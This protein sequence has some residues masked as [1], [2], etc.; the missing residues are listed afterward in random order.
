MRNNRLKRPA[1]RK[2]PQRKRYLV[3]VEG[4]VTEREY[5]DAVRRFH[6]I[7]KDNV[8]TAQRNTEPIGIVNYAKELQNIARKTDA[9][10][11]V[12][13]VFDTETKLTQQARHGLNDAI[14]MARDVGFECAISNPCFELWLLWHKQDRFRWIASDEVQRLCRENEITKDDGK[15]LSNAYDLYASS[16]I[17]ARNRADAAE[18]RHQNNGTTTPEDKNPSS[19]VYKLIEAIH[20]AFPARE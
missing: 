14:A 8:K 7:S 15:H 1:S 9:Y 16:F 10:D 17:N 4:A 20:E 19:G 12:W 3:V 2:L 6:R 5:F 11:E 13:C 18:T